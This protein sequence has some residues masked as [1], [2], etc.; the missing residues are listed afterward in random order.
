MATVLVREGTLHK[1]GD[2]VLCGFE[3]AVAT[4]DAWLS[5]VRKCWKRVRPVPVEILDAVKA[6]PA[7]GDEVT[8]VR[9]EK[10]RV[11]CSVSS[12]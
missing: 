12:G 6:F 11:S 3:Y 8:V 5:W 9:D 2:I 10:K 4:C 7:A 1:R